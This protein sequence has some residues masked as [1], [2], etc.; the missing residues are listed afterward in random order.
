MNSIDPGSINT[1]SAIIESFDPASVIVFTGGASYT[2][3]GAASVVDRA[4]TSRSATYIRNIAPNPDL[5]AVNEA[6]ARYRSAEPELVVAVGGGSTIDLAKVVNAVAPRSQDARAYILGER[7]FDGAGAPLVAIPTTSGT[8]SE[9]TRYAV[10]TV[11]GEKVPVGH[12]ALL[13]AHVILDPQLSY[14][15]PPHV[16]AVTGLDALA[17]AMES[18]WSVRSDAESI[19]TASRALQLAVDNI[20]AVVN[21]PDPP[22]RAAM[23]EASHLSGVAINRA[24]TSAPHAL[25]FH[26]T[27]THGVPH[28]HAVALTLG[29][30]LEYI[31]GVDESDILDPR[32]VRH[33]AST[34][35]DITDILKVR[36]PGAGRAKLYDLIEAVGLEPTLGGVGAGSREAKDAIAGA[37]SRVRLANSPCRFDRHSLRSML[38]GIA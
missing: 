26:L 6:I 29:G 23:L 27:T 21:R 16:S 38:S 24:P 1:L 18:M 28:G 34:V 5:D 14:S 32:G 31:G 7:P 35:T 10:I 17:Q 22:S 15:L 4:L 25:S 36:D 12:D 2:T 11:D 19:G 13:P 33:V 20:E 3:S 8:G 37:V 30:V 9:A